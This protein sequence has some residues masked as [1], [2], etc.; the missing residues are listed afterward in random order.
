MGLKCALHS[1]L[2]QDNSTSLEHTGRQQ[3][4]PVNYQYTELVA[5]G[6][7]VQ[8]DNVDHVKCDESTQKTNPM[9]NELAKVKKSHTH[10]HT[11]KLTTSHWLTIPA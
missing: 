1:S 2:Q 7:G 10:T 9:T 6:F 8:L 3:V 4:T 5:L 11:Q